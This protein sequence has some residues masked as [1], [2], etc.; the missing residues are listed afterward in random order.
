MVDA[1]NYLKLDGPEIPDTEGLLHKVVFNDESVGITLLD[2][3]GWKTCINGELSPEGKDAGYNEM[4]KTL[5]KMIDD[6]LIDFAILDVIWY[7]VN[8]ASGLTSIV[9]CAVGG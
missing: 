7:G 1:T 4:Y 6:N 9:R 5:D 3:K 8:E 2:N